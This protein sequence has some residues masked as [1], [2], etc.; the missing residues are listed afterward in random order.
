MSYCES[1]VFGKLRCLT[2]DPYMLCHRKIASLG[3]VV[4]VYTW[5]FGISG[6]FLRFKGEMPLR[7]LKGSDP[8]IG[9][10]MRLLSMYSGGSLSEKETVSELCSFRYPCILKDPRS[11]ERY[12]TG[13]F[14]FPT[15]G[16]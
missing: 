2:E 4:L 7:L 15:E 6:V 9:Y 1:G 3:K 5:L 14:F 11:V 13:F 16:S 10:L 12:P 8:E